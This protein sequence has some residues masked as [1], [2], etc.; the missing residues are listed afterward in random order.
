MR[1]TEISNTEGLSLDTENAKAM[2]ANNSK[3]D[4]IFCA[5]QSVSVPIVTFNRLA[6]DALF[7]SHRSNART[8]EHI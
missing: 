8:L 2:H 7:I 4:S 6:I 5:G 3:H 1:I